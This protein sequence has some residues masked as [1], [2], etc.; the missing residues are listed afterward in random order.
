M[1]IVEKIKERLRG[2]YVIWTIVFALSCLSILVVYSAVSARAFRQ[3]GGN[4]EY[5]LFRHVFFLVI[6]LL[7]MWM[8]HLV[9]YKYFSKLSHLLLWVSAALLI[10]TVF[11]GETTNQAT[12]RL[13]V[14]FIGI[15]F[16]PSDLAKLALISGLARMLSKRQKNIED[17]KEAV[18]PMLLW[19]GVICGLIALSDFSTAGLLFLGCMVVMFMGRVSLK[20]I[21]SLVGF[22]I[23]AL[24][25]ALSYGTRKETAQRRIHDWW[26]VMT[27]DVGATEVPYQVEHANMAIATGGIFGK[28]YGNSQ[29]RY[30]L[31]EAYADYIY[32]IIIEE[33]GLLIGTLVL[34]LYLGLFYRGMRVMA[35]SKD[36]YGGLLAAGLS[37]MLVIQALVHM[38]VVVGVGPVTGL[39][40]PFL[41]MGGT[42]LLFSGVSIGV[43]LSVSRVNYEKEQSLNVDNLSSEE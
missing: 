2:D 34:L 21:L 6:S 8:T 18:L 19:C 41:S 42:S 3:T 1:N 36:P 23:I 15:T 32:A 35:R 16:Q 14:P 25:L 33:G 11:F 30:F 43:V 24:A 13:V 26:A 31:P 28:G 7:A 20:H 38:A 5:Y 39:P 22:I 27:D 4:T 40:L 29:E 37:F 10:F 17:F 9:D 12:R